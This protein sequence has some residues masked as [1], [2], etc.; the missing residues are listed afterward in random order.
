METPSTPSFCC[1]A[2]PVTAAIPAEMM[3]VDSAWNDRVPLSTR[4]T[5]LSTGGTRGHPDFDLEALETS[6]Q[7]LRRRCRERPV[8]S[9]SK[10]QRGVV[11][12]LLHHEECSG[13]P[14]A[15][16]RDQLVTVNPV[17]IRH[18]GDPDFQ[19]IVEVAGDQVAIEDE[20]QFRDGFFE[21]R[22]TLR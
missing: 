22:E 17:E 6:R 11:D 15:R 8:E 3:G 21:R 5:A 12:D 20:F 1:H 10:L 9:R 19:E 13:L 18:I 14:N 7:L 4:P 16:Q 2:P